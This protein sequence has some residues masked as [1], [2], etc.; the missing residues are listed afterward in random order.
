MEWSQDCNYPPLFGSDVRLPGMET[1]QL[2]IS[3]TAYAAALRGLLVRTGGWNVVTVE[4]PNTR[5]DGVVVVD[6]NALE[7]L[8]SEIPNPDRV[9]LITPND[10]H[11]LSRAWEAGIVSVVFDNDPINT[12]L[13]AIMAARLRVPKTARQDPA[14]PPSADGAGSERG[15]E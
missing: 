8:P 10:P 3:D 9:V 5:A 13:L 14:A 4:S 6:S 15:K 1:I 7:R 11:L 2:A 12:A